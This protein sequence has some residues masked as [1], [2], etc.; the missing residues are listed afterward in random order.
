L[1]GST[2]DFFDFFVEP[3]G[4]NC[5]AA[6]A[7]DDIDDDVPGVGVEG[8]PF[9]LPLGPAER[10]LPLRPTGFFFSFLAGSDRRGPS[11]L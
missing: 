4:L 1:E 9:E 11:S 3:L 5:A 10:F 8:F 6:V 2:F 7:A